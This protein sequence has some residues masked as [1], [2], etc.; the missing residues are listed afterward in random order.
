MTWDA[1]CL[2]WAEHIG[3]DVG[4]KTAQRYAVS[5]KQIDGF[6]RSLHVDEIDRGVVS[7]IVKARR[8]AGVSTA[9]IRR[10]LTALSRVLAFA[11]DE[12]WREG[13]PALERLRRLKE[14]RDP[15]VLPQTADIEAVIARAPGNFKALIRAAWLT[16]C[17]QEELVAAER[18]RLDHRAQQLTVIGKGNKLRVIQ[19]S[20]AAYALFRSL[21]VNLATKWLFWH[22]DG[23]DYA[24]V[25]SR[26][27]LFVDQV[28]GSAQRVGTE[29]HPFR[30]HDL[31]HRYAVDYLKGGGNLYTLQG[32]L[33]HSSVKTTE[34]YLKYLTP[35]EAQRAK[36]ASER[37]ENASPRRAG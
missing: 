31:R 16:G 36:F 6:L 4:A 20:E 2:A 25:S 1:A 35:E 30:F 21:P 8:T 29:F 9:T 27:G 37:G 14:K 33:G 23:E 17:R 13:N 11:E 18:R 3:H 32:Q 26:F 10:D 12:E 22:H 24:N 28:A 15:I 34:I 19:L 5:L 7:D